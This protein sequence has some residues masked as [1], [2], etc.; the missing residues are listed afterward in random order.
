MGLERYSEALADFESELQLDPLFSDA[1]FGRA[2]ALVG[3]GRTD[4]ALTALELVIV[5]D[6]NNIDAIEAKGALERSP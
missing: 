5:L 4:E 3:L 6:P 1:W 2:L